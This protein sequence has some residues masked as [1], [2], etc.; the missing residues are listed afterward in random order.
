QSSFFYVGPRTVFSESA[1]NYYAQDVTTHTLDSI[2][3]PLQTLATV[4]AQG[5]ENSDFV[6]VDCVMIGRVSVV[7]SGSPT[8]GAKGHLG[9]SIW[10][11]YNTP[12]A[13][14]IF[15]SIID[16]AYQEE[17]ASSFGTNGVSVQNPNPPTGNPQYTIIAYVQDPSVP[18]CNAILTFSS[19]MVQAFPS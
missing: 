8:P 17:P 2:D 5:V 3:D 9:M 4:T 13:A 11:D 14:L 19:I 7:T 10:R 16:D 12:Q 6:R 1:L 15:D 18:R